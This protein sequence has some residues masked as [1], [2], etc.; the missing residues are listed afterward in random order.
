MKK[1]GIIGLSLLAMTSCGE[2]AETTTEAKTCT[3]INK[4]TIDCGDLETLKEIEKI[5]SD[6]ESMTM[7]TPENTALAA[8]KNTEI[9]ALIDPLMAVLE[10]AI[11][12]DPKLKE[13][14]YVEKI[15]DAKKGL[16]NYNQALEDIK[17][18]EIS[19]S[20]GPDPK[21]PKDK[22]VTVKFKNT[23]TR[24]IKQLSGV[25]TYKDA[26]GTVLA[27]ANVV[28]YSFHFTPSAED[29]L[30]PG[31]EGTSDLGINCDKDKR[32]SIATVELVINAISYVD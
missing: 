10:K 32:P 21:F 28:F 4:V 11:E 3:T 18:L 25:M 31:Y 29:S 9:L 19:A 13:E 15:Y 20:W 5:S 8:E 26:A 17:N 2:K 23:S 1:I 24:A 14:F 27:E 16:A 30:A 6:L 12:A 7:L 22:S